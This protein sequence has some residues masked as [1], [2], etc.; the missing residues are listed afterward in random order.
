MWCKSAHI[1]ATNGQKQMAEY[2][3]KCPDSKLILSGFSQ[4]GSVALDILGGGGGPGFDCEN[5]EYN[6]PMSKTEL[7]GKN[8]VAATVFGAV[9]RSKNQ[10][11]TVQTSKYVDF[12]GQNPRDF[13]GKAPRSEESLAVLDKYSSILRDYCNIGDP[14]CA[15]D[16]EPADVARHLNYFDFYSEEAAAWVIEKASGKK[17][18]LDKPSSSS[19]TSAP[20]KTPTHASSAAM[21]TGHLDAQEQDQEPEKSVDAQGSAASVSLGLSL[22]AVVVLGSLFQLA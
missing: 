1:G 19:T 5:Q 12:Q 7:P 15:R 6:P 3:A 18:K 16:S 10:K 11:Y 17:V 2:A 4:G 20:T 13:D 9:V 22:A 21:S 8:L 14:V